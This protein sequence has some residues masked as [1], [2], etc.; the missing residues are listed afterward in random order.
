MMFIAYGDL[1]IRG[2]GKSGRLEFKSYSSSWASVC[3][4]GFNDYAADI[5]CRQ[6]GYLQSTDVFTY[7]EYVIYVHMVM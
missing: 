2:G 5:A 4:S 7:N 1:R 3:R 6:L